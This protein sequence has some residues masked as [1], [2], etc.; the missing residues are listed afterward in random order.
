MMVAIAVAVA[1][2]SVLA[3]VLLAAFDRPPA[4][5]DDPRAGETA[6]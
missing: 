3:G 6:P 4:D 2:L 1:L 5:A